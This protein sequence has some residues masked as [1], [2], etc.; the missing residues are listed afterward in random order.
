MQRSW[1]TV[2]S[3]VSAQAAE[4]SVPSAGSFVKLET[5]AAYV[6]FRFSAIST[7]GSPTVVKVNVWRQS[8]SKIDRLAVIEFTS[9]ETSPKP[10]IVEFH[11][12]STYVTFEF[13]GG[14][15]PTVTVSEV[16]ARPVY[17]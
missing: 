16:Q 7:S 4:T 9:S 3:S 2:R 10:Q 12:D 15:S 8:G 11:G 6:E 14:S 17:L 13:T 1:T 5:E